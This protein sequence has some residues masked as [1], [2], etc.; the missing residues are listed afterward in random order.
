M[1]RA[2]FEEFIS[3]KIPQALF[4]VSRQDMDDEHQVHLDELILIEILNTNPTLLKYKPLHWFVQHF[5]ES[6][7]GKE[8]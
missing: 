7:N 1:T 8:K 3:E 4:H 5:I 6:E 2:E